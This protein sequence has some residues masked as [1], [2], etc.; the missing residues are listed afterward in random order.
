MGKV[1]LSNLTD[2]KQLLLCTGHVP[3]KENVQWEKF[4]VRSFII[5]RSVIMSEMQ[6]AFGMTTKRH[7]RFTRIK[8]ERKI[9]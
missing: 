6:D 7:K 1:F 2:S 3:S 4:V 9:V 8:D 5:K